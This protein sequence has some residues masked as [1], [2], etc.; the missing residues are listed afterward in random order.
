MKFYGM[1][2]HNP[3]TNRID[4]KVK[5]TKRSKGQNRFANNSVQ[6]GVSRDKN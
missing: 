1:V 2:G 3:W 4:F 6:N 5:V